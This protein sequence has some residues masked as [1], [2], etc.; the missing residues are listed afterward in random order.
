MDY[1]YRVKPFVFRWL[2]LVS[3]KIFQSYLLLNSRKVS[4][5]FLFLFICREGKVL[6][7]FNYVYFLYQYLIDNCSGDWI[8]QKDVRWPCGVCTKGVGSN[9]IQ[10][11][12]CQKWVHKKCSGIMGSMSKVAKS[13]G[14]FLKM[15]CC[16]VFWICTSTNISQ[17]CC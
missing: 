4:C 6:M 11:S 10:C 2:D 15:L 8:W 9:S 16:Y 14:S 7:C 12:S 17:S 1:V 5:L 3:T 13:F